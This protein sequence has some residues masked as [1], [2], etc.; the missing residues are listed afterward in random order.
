MM[1]MTA[2]DF[3]ELILQHDGTIESSHMGHPDFRANGRIFA[4]LTADERRG[5]LSLA[6]DEQASLIQAHPRTFEAAN[7]AWGRQG[8][9][10]VSLQQ[11][12]AAAV[13]GAVLLAWQG[14][15]SRP[16]PRRRTAKKT[17]RSSSRKTRS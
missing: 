17:A 5:T 13:R 2:D 7:G 14:V 15:M 12:D 6:P 10:V 8:W 16:A 1:H 4:S 9:T 3:R 11:A